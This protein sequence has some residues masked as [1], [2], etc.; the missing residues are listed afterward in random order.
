L[1]RL[2]N[3]FICYIIFFIIKLIGLFELTKSRSATLSINLTSPQI[4]R[5]SLLMPCGIELP[6]KLL[7]CWD[8]SL[9]GVTTA[10]EAC[11]AAHQKIEKLYFDGGTDILDY[12]TSL[13][14]VE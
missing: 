8:R 11:F 14:V 6:G 12:F 9:K 13:L 1:T 3:S 2:I 4:S 10:L 7:F 5:T